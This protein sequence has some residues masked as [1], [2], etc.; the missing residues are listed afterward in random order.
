MKKVF[1][2]ETHSISKNLFD[3]NKIF[4]ILKYMYTKNDIPPILIKDF[5]K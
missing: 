4:L 2:G 3:R 5:Q 1:F